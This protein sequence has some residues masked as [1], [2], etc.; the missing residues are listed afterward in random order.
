MFRYR[1]RTLLLMSFLAPPILAGTH[2]HWEPFFWRYVWPPPTSLEPGTAVW[3]DPATGR[4][5]IG[6]DGSGGC[7]Q[8]ELW[9]VPSDLDPSRVYMWKPAADGSLQSIRF[10]AASREWVTEPYHPR[11]NPERHLARFSLCL[12]ASV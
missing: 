5:A 12:R 9:P 11:S 2:N 3:I 1:L 8:V 10:D 7:S 6:H 4:W